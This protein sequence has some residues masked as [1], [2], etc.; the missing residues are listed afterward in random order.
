LEPKPALDRFERPDRCPVC[1]GPRRKPYRKGN[2]DYAGL[3]KDQ[4]KITD[5]EY[6]KIWDLS[7]CPDCGHIFADPAPKPEF[8]FDLYRQVEDP[9]YDVESEGRSQNFR[10]ILKTLD[11]LQPERGT[12]FDVGAATGILLE[13]ARGRGWTPD[14]I[15]ASDWAAECA[16]RT[17]NLPLRQGNFEEA[18][19]A[20]GSCRAVTMVDFIEHTPRPREAVAKAREILAPGGVLCLVTPDIHSLAAR[21]AGR[22]WWHL[23]PGHLAYFSKKS[24]ATLLGDAGFTILRRKRYAWTFSAHY[25]LTRLKAFRFLVRGRRAAMI[26]KKIPIKLALRDSFEI[27]ARKDPPK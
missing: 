14:G 7:R 4:I 1:A 8:I 25:L 6:G 9:A 12:L 22:R 13:A 26:F 21:L 19:V 11:G 23:R 5:A 27:Y 24:L 17:R 16:R 2:F 3:D 15:D 20:P 10:W 18:D